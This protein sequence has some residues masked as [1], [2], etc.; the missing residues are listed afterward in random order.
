[1][2]S[3]NVCPRDGFLVD[4]TAGIE[5]PLAKTSTTRIRERDMPASGISLGRARKLKKVSAHGIDAR[6]L[7]G[8][9]IRGRC[10]FR[11]E[12][13]NYVQHTHYYNLRVT[14]R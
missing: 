13:R 3:S 7:G 2:T 12:S 10:R 8:V 9:E 5:R 1:M 6:A 4:V 11:D 14:C